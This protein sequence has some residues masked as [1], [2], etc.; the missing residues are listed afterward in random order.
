MPVVVRTLESLGAALRP[1]AGVVG[2][3]GMVG[4]M[5]VVGAVR[6]SASPSPAVLRVRVLARGI[7]CPVGARPGVC[8]GV[9]RRVAHTGT[10]AT[11]TI[12]RQWRPASSST[13][14]AIRATGAA[15]CIVPR[16]P[17]HG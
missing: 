8:V 2:V 3:M 14:G 1:G 7:A 10:M 9:C 15:P 11:P 5:G 12:A 17:A 6:V 13:L 4:V 16:R